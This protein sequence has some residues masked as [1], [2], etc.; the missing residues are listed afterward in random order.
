AFTGRWPRAVRLFAWARVRRELLAGQLERA[1]NIAGRI[2]EGRERA[3]GS[4][5]RFS[6]DAED[7]TIGRIRLHLHAGEHREALRLL[8][9]CLRHAVSGGRVHR[10]MKLH[11]LAAIARRKAGNEFQAHRSLEQA[12]SL[13]AP[14]QYVRALLDE[15]EDMTQL[16]LEY[17]GT[18]AA[19]RDGAGERSA[20]RFLVRLLEASG[21]E[22]PEPAGNT[23]SPRASCV[24]LEEF[25]DRERQI[26]AQIVNYMSNAQIAA[27]LVVT[28]DTVKFHIKNIYAKLGVKNRLEAIRAVRQRG[29]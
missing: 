7:G 22:A 29:A 19:L 26:L 13:A 15:G 17:L 9:Q 27:N 12:L 10:Q 25:T 24:R 6:E 14:G 20:D 5:V 3:D 21:T 2:Q 23:R 4:L 1:R 8:Q 28:R 16:M 11:A 18:R